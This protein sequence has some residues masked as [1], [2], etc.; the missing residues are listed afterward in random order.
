MEKANLPLHGSSTIYKHRG[1]IRDSVH[2]SMVWT[3]L[4]Q[5]VLLTPHTDSDQLSLSCL[6]FCISVCGWFSENLRG[7]KE[8][9]KVKS[10]SNSSIW[11]ISIITFLY[12]INRFLVKYLKNMTWVSSLCSLSRNTLLHTLK[13]RVSE[14]FYHIYNSTLKIINSKC[15]IFQS[16]F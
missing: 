12:I 10:V 1:V 13:K 15:V 5:D 3:S 6:M 8:N 7:F 2:I 4:D 9:S 14:L 16:L 11:K